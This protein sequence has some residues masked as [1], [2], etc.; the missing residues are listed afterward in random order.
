MV[1]EA[2]T[3]PVE[4][5]LTRE[6]AHG[7]LHEILVSCITAQSS[8]APSVAPCDLF[9]PNLEPLPGQDY[10]AQF[11][12]PEPLLRTNQCTRYERTTVSLLCKQARE[13]VTYN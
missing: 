10:D 2:R 5:D 11:G 9:A 1:P 8:R 4:L 13:F 6:G 3:R 7:T 12:A